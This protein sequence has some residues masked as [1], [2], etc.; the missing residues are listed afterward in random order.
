MDIKRIL[1]LNVMVVAAVA[2]AGKCLFPSSGTTFKARPGTQVRQTADGWLDVSCDGTYGWPGVELLPRDGGT[3]DF[4]RIGAIEVVVSNMGE[5]VEFLAADVFPKGSRNRDNLPLRGATVPPGETRLISVQLA[6]ERVLTDVPVALEGTNGKIGSAAKALCYR[7]TQQVEVFQCQ[8]GNLHP[9]HFAVL[10]V[11][12]AFAAAKPAIIAA[13][14]FFPFC[15]RYGQF[16]HADWPGKIHSDDEL[17][18]ARRR[19]EAWLA[20][21]RE[22]PIP[23]ADKY[24]GW[25]G[26]PQLAATGFFRTEK[27]DGRWWLVD[28]EGHLFFSLGIAA[29]YAW[30]QTL[31]SGREKYFEW[32]P[33]ALAKSWRN[34]DK[35]VDFMHENLARK[36]GVE[37]KSHFADTTHRRF[38]AWGINT[39]GNW[40]HEYIYG[41]RRTPYVA[42]IDPSSAKRLSIR[43][44]KGLG[45]IVPDV[46]SPQFVKDVRGQLQKLALKIKDDPWC[47]GVYV[48]NELDWSSPD[49]VEGA[50]EKYFATI[51]A[52][53]K[54]VLPNHLYLGC[55]FVRFQP[56]V[57]RVASRYCDVVS[58]NF[59]ERHPTWN[60]PP[61]A[62]DKPV[63]VGEFH[64]GALDRGNL[65]SGCA[66]T[67]DQ[68]ERAQCFKD[69]VNACLDNP[70]YVG[71]HWFQYSDQAVTGRY[72]DGEAYQIGFVSVCD[73]P[74]PELVGACRETAANMYQRHLSAR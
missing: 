65:A 46:Y 74:Y 21:H 60:L 12:T 17:L 43:K 29:V 30:T 47:I 55:R 28:P 39:M 66:R 11:R 36:Y 14:N 57:W 50:A 10:G 52:E 40:S 35:L 27:V 6:D 25:K 9:L 16:K 26:G 23:D 73:I 13:T 1:S 54:A 31:A 20:A 2:I 61:D 38:R 58:F 71:C 45:A 53:I 15:D 70:R 51:A 69:Y 37:W 42:T 64:F 8:P 44:K 67:F 18:E 7:E 5:R 68:R 19:E 62:M 56:E 33:S 4:S 59:Y 3:W 48:D 22:S 24:G 41:L 34:D 32:L 72:Y 63:I 49:N